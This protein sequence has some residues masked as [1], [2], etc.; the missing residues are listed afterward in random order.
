V[1]DYLDS[2]SKSIF[3]DSYHGLKRDGPI[4]RQKFHTK[5]PWT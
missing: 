4:A 3:R 5:V 1:D 2:N